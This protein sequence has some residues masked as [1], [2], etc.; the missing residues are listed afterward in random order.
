MSD[1]QEKILGLLKDNARLSD[2]KL[3][4]MLGISTQEVSD[5]IQK[6]EKSG[7]ICGYGVFI[8]EDKLN[9]ESVTAL[10]EIK[11]M[12]KAKL[13]YKDNARTIAQFSEVE[14]V[15]LM[16]GDYDLVLKV[17]CNSLKEVGRFVDEKL[18]SIDG[19]LKISTHF[20]IGRYKESGEV[21]D[22]DYS[23]DERGLVSP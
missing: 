4:V 18:S 11:V 14:A 19:I 7:I 1:M 2:E 22:F 15:Y 8:N 3:A 6:L 5:E 9:K 12:P 20:I 17:K 13:G 10:I 23:S 16:S 21:F